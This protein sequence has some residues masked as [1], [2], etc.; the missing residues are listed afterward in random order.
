MTRIYLSRILQV[1]LCLLLTQSI[2]GQKLEISG[3]ELNH[4]SY[5]EELNEYFTDYTLV[6]PA[7]SMSSKE[8]APLQEIDLDLVLGSIETSIS[9]TR[10]ELLSSRYKAS[11]N[12]NDEINS[13]NYNGYVPK[14][15]SSKASLSIVNGDLYGFVIWQGTRYW[16]ESASKFDASLPRH[17]LIVY[18]NS[19]VI[20]S[21]KQFCASHEVAKH[22]PHDK[23]RTTK[24]TEC[25]LVE[26]AIAL[27][28]SYVSKHGGATGA[29]E[30]SIAVMNMVA[31]NYE[32]SFSSNI[33]F[34]IV[35]H[36]LETNAN[37]N[38]WGTSL[39]ASVLLNAFS[40]WGP[41]G[42][43]NTHDLGQLWT[44][45]NIWD[46]NAQGQ[47]TNGIA[48]LA[49]V[50][51]VCG[52][53]R[54]HILEDYSSTA[55]ALRVLVAH[56]M[57]H[58]FGAGHDGAAGNIMAGTISQNTNTWS[59]GSINSINSMLDGFTCM[60]ECLLGSCSE[61]VDLRTFGCTPGNPATYSLSFE[62][63]HGGGTGAGFEVNVDGQV[64]AFQWSTSPQEIIIPGLVS[65]GTENII[66]INALDGSDAGCNG[67]AVYFEPADDCSF[68]ESVDFND[69]QI[70][71]GWTSTTTQGSQINGGDPFVQY[72]W[73]FLDANR[74]IGNYDVGDNAGSLLTIDGTC[75]AIMD[76]DIF[77]VNWYSGIVALTTAEYDLS[78]FDEVL[79][80]FDYNFHPF[81]VGKSAN[82][83]Y[84]SV[85]VWDG[86]RYIE[87]LRDTDTN[88]PW[89]NAWQPSCNDFFQMNVTEFANSDMHFRFIHSDGNDGSWAGMA[90]FDNFK[91]TGSVSQTDSCP[92]QISLVP[93][94][95]VTEANDTY[96]AGQMIMTTGDITVS[97]SATFLSPRVEFEG[98]F[99]V[100][101]G[102]EFQVI[103]IGCNTF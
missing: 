89:S 50:G 25:E 75:M 32:G 66:T 83:S 71:D 22:T 63:A 13:L 59:S 31:A 12:K 65:N 92:D 49:W 94:G 99:E 72:N 38:T 87:I 81:E 88:C 100:L 23:P 51:A 27:D 67:Q 90:S 30:Q 11:D 54:Y 4:K 69:C 103:S 61:I 36:F 1:F 64:F 42:F 40:A 7:Y 58:N 34:E 5:G 56:E 29:K 57:G 91:L 82:N 9:L 45:D 85:E 37:Q 76:D 17:T 84:F 80:S 86:I 2:T 95:E 98:G 97:S 55:W 79:V 26:L 19:D 16:I 74:T 73:K 10:N 21:E 8:L 18:K 96:S 52:S 77:N 101:T 33:R 60:S 48:G 3:P 35:E 68:S 93:T 41:N 14:D 6:R 46:N 78:G 15:A 20:A 24:S 39:Q 53:L 43:S 44:A 102:A 62:L 47:P 28:Y 70:P